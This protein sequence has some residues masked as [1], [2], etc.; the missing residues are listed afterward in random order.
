MADVM[1]ARPE[2]A[3]E[4]GSALSLGSLILYLPPQGISL[5]AVE[6]AAI[7]Q[8]LE[9]NDWSQKDAALFLGVSARVINYKVAQHGITHRRWHRNKPQ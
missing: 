6:R 4:D 8:A 3:D 2:D 5:A 7:I 1:E 9:K